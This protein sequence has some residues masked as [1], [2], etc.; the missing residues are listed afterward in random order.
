MSLLPGVKVT[1]SAS[2]LYYHP[3]WCETFHK[4]KKVIVLKAVRLF[5]GVNL[6]QI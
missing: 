6:C 2:V 3:A 1:V 4:A 5:T